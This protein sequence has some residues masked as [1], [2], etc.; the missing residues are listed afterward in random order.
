[1]TPET[2]VNTC[3]DFS[4]RLLAA[5]NHLAPVRRTE[6]LRRGASMGSTGLKAAIAQLAGIRSQS[7]LSDMLAGR[8]QGLQYRTALAT[9]LGIDTTWLNTGAG[10]APPWTLAPE[11]AFAT[12]TDHLH[13]SWRRTCAQRSLDPALPEE[14]D[15]DE[16][17][18]FLALGRPTDAR[19][20]ATPAGW[21]MLQDAFG[22]DCAEAVQLAGR[23]LGE[24]PFD[25]LVRFAGWLGEPE[26]EHP[27]ILRTG[28]RVWLRGRRHEA[29][30]TRSLLRGL[31]R[32]WLPQ[33]LFRL[34]REALMAHKGLRGYRGE[35]T[36]DID[37]ALEI[38]WR[39]DLV[40]RGVEPGA[41]VPEELTQ[42]TGRTAWTPVHEFRTRH[43]TADD[44]SGAFAAL[45]KRLRLT[46]TDE[47]GTA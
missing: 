47:V 8:A 2:D 32:S 36:V 26:P 17:N 28:Q 15:C 4:Q 42:E 3:A 38:L 35:D 33:R 45:P 29:G 24:A 25:L 5:I 6:I 41:S 19:D 20:D 14:G 43:G 18:P 12:W 9:V 44:Q 27:E 22:I 34:C 31:R 16:D 7:F 11:D 1:M 13:D 40:A 21:A 39:I 30:H 23:N 46:P 37:D 10:I